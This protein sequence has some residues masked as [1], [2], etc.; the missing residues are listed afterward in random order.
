MRRRLFRQHPHGC[1]DTGRLNR[2]DFL[3]LATG[4]AA[5]ASEQIRCF[6]RQE[7]AADAG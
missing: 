7:V 2:R 4:G 3:R 1:R 6:V 5:A